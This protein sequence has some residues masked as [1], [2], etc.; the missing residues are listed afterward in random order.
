MLMRLQIFLD[1]K[2]AAAKKG[3]I[4]TDCMVSKVI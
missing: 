4:S 2:R 1:G 3:H